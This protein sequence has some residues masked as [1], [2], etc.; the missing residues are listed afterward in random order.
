MENLSPQP[1]PGRS[2]FLSRKGLHLAIHEREHNGMEM[3]ICLMYG[4]VQL[5][6]G[7]RP[8]CLSPFYHH[9]YMMTWTCPHNPATAAAAAL[10]HFTCLHNAH[11]STHTEEAQ[12]R[13]RNTVHI[14]R[15]R[16]LLW[17]TGKVNIMVLFK[18][19]LHTRLAREKH[20]YE[21]IFTLKDS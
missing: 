3:C 1:T 14:Y 4:R 8:T 5:Y 11:L 16:E 18:H 9:L 15:E 10:M 2:L 13:D 6:Q 7:I 20:T 17:T 12:T 19:S 21:H